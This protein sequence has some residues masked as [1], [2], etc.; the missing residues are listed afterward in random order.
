MNAPQRSLIL[1]GEGSARNGDHHC[2]HHRDKAPHFYSPGTVS[3]C[4]VTEQAR[5]PGTARAGA[6]WAA[7]GYFIAQSW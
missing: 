6:A 4:Y 1:L 2:E 3:E 5:G 7:C